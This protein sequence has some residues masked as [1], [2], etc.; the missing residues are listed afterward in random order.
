MKFKHGKQKKYGEKEASLFFLLVIISSPRVGLNLPNLR[1][2][3]F[4][5]VIMGDYND[6]NIILDPV[7]HKV[8]GV[9][10][11]GDAVR[12]YLKFEKLED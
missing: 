6:A 7:K 12:M 11:F 5:Q 10:D 3:C 2:H 9:I 4:L 8:A 1:F